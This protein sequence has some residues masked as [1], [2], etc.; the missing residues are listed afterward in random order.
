MPVLKLPVLDV[1]VFALLL[2]INGQEFKSLALAWNFL[3][4]RLNIIA[5]I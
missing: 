1:R 5:K 4:V 2:Q 3:A